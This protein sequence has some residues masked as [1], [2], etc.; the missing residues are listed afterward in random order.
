M[1]RHV[2]RR[3]PRQD[4]RR[5]ARAGVRQPGL[6]RRDQP[7]RVLGAA[8]ARQLADDACAAAASQGSAVLPAGKV[9][10][11]REVEERRQQRPRRDFAGIDQLRDRPAPRFGARSSARD[12]SPSASAQLVVPRSMPTTKRLFRGGSLGDFDFGGRDDVRPAG[13]GGRS[14]GSRPSRGG[15]GRR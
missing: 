11:A 15:A 3:A 10:L 12:V 6:R 4:R 9:E 1:L 13:S 7:R 5:A 14:S 2:L 8:L